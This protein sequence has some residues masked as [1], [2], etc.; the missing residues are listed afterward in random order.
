MDPRYSKLAKILTTYS[1][2]VKPHTNV[3][4]RCLGLPALPLAREVMARVLQAGAH[5]YLDI[6]DETSGPAF[7]THAQEHQLKEAPH[8]EKFIANWATSIITIVG[9][10]NSRT[11]ADC[12]PHK[13]LMRQVSKKEIRAITMSKPWVLT[14]VPTHSLAQDAGMSLEKFTEF[15]FDATLRNWKNEG[16]EFTR[17]AKIFNR[18]KE[19]QVIGEDTDLHVKVEGRKFVPDNG[20]CNMPGGEIF[21]APLDDG[22]DGHVYFNYPLLRTG[23][24]I[25][26][27]RLTFKQGKV[28]KA[29]ASENENFLHKI[30]DTDLGARTLGEFAI[31]LNTGVP[32]YMNSVLFDEKIAGTIHMALGEAYKECGGTN[33][34]TIHMDIVK[35]MRVPGSKLIADGKVVMQDGRLLL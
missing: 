17:L 30:L 25:R 12:D 8:I 27:I 35:D 1:V 9:E 19:I 3:W 29:S 13:L 11:L 23:K 4:I 24:F 28:V 21:T 16:K 20:E 33:K 7:Y 32:V 18:F 31:G 5:S 26:D 34:S 22:V 6:A 2:K 10:E 14:Y 15:Y